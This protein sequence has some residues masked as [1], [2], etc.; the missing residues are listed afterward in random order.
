MEAVVTTDRRPSSELVKDAK[1]LA[2]K[3]GFPYVKRRHKTIEEIK[4]E[5]GKNVLVVRKDFNIVVHT[6]SGSRLFFHPGLFKIRLL[7]YL[8]TGHEAMV[9][10]MDLKEGD[11]VLDCNL[12]LAQ[13][14]LL[15]AFVTNREVIGIE[16]DPVIAEMVRRGLNS[17]KPSG[18]L[19][20]ASKAFKMVKVIT[21]DNYDYLR[22]AKSKSFDIV[23]FSP[24]FI[25]PKW[26]CD[27]M[28]P[29]REVAVKDFLT[30]EV[31]KEAE[32]V[33][34]KRVVVKVNKGIKEMFTFFQSYKLKPSS[35]NVEYLYK[36]V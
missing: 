28:A 31:L 36:E 32:R 23:Y 13:D 19:K 34:R 3:L 16:K 21:A 12:G 26:H 10:A 18:K 5:F 22:K 11:T 24:M 15:A 25:K 9:D 30:P 27:V 6:I 33:A 20:I 35:T 29:M 8:R 1:E 14:A 4:R 17:Y 7:N 2:E